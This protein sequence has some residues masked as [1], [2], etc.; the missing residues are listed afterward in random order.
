[1]V[2]GQD[3]MQNEEEKLV[4][5][6]LVL[7]Q[8][9]YGYQIIQELSKHKNKAFYKKEGNIY[10]I[11]HELKK[12]NYITAKDLTNLQGRVRTCYE[13]T[14]K[15]R[16]YLAKRENYHNDN[17]SVLTGTGPLK[18][19]LHNDEGIYSW[20]KRAVSYILYKK[21]REPIYD[22]LC[23]H[24]IDKSE[25]LIA[26]GVTKEAATA[27]AIDEM[28]DASFVGNALKRIH[29]PYSG[30]LLRVSRGLLIASMLLFV[31]ARRHY[32]S[33]SETYE[34]YYTQP[35]SYS[36]EMYLSADE[37]SGITVLKTCEQKVKAGPYKISLV[38][39]LLSQYSE[40][41]ATLYFTL[42][43]EYGLLQLPPD[44]LRIYMTAVDS[45]GTEYSD[46]M[47]RQSKYVCGNRENQKLFSCDYDLWVD[48]IEE[49]IEWIDIIYNK[50]DVNLRFRIL[51][52]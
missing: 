29:K 50:N 26:H 31:Y 14:K 4:L 6:S 39:A 48:G 18:A 3:K 25:D 2:R 32:G 15:G 47:L 22:E 41:K 8:P 52:N 23:Y 7:E 28:G 24:L 34:Y 46:C 44:F 42:H 35:R 30:Y 45:N 12:Y 49:E 17:N 16:S 13:I 27:I 33:V 37:N 11:L 20:C 19:Q 43:A 10:P 51:L 40:A 36:D 5:L 1:M 9:M 21:D 38:R